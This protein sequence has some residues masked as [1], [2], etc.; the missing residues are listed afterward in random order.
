VWV[1]KKYLP[2]LLTTGR[3]VQIGVILKL[4]NQKISQIMPRAK[5]TLTYHPCVANI[6]FSFRRAIT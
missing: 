1:F 4:L 6:Y 3:L 2:Q 5:R